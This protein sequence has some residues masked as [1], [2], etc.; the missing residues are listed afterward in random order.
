VITERIALIVGAHFKRF[1]DET[2]IDMD[3]A[4][5]LINAYLPDAPILP[6]IFAGGYKTLCNY[7]ETVLEA[8][9]KAGNREEKHPWNTFAGVLEHGYVGPALMREV[10]D[11]A[12]GGDLSPYI[13]WLY[14]LASAGLDRHH[15]IMVV[16]ATG[17]M[18]EE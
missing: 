18:M 12:N 1:E 15:L 7:M 3:E 11:L 4:L 5:G 6:Q 13:T 10:L 8:D 14:K 9:T 2:G 16:K 17:E